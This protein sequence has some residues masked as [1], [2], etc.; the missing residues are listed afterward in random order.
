MAHSRGVVRGRTRRIT[1]R[2]QFLL[3][4]PR[5]GG[6]FYLELIAPARGRDLAASGWRAVT[7]GLLAVAFR[8]RF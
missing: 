4:D 1:F 8:V 7:L 6:T 5:T 3:A 2:K